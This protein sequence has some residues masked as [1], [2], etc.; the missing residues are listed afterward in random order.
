MVMFWIPYT[1]TAFSSRRGGRARR[2]PR[3]V[4]S[5]VGGVSELR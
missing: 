1:T 3:G 4:F 2:P 5:L